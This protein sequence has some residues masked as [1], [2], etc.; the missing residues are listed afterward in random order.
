MANRVTQFVVER[1]LVN[2]TATLARTT[3]FVVERLVVFP[4][5]GNWNGDGATAVSLSALRIGYGP[6]EADGVTNVGFTATGKHLNTPLRLGKSG[7]GG[8]SRENAGP[9]T[10]KITRRLGRYPLGGGI[11][12]LAYTGKQSSV[13]VTGVTNVYFRWQVNTVTDPLTAKLAL[14]FSKL[15]KF[16]LGYNAQIRST[17]TLATAQATGATSVAIT[18][19]NNTSD[20]NWERFQLPNIDTGRQNVATDFRKAGTEPVAG[21]LYSLAN[22]G[23]KKILP[24][25]A[26]SQLFNST[27]LSFITTRP[28]LAADFKE[29]Y[30]FNTTTVWPSIS[31]FTGGIPNGNTFSYYRPIT[32][33]HSQVSGTPSNFP[34]LIQGTFSWLA[35]VAN[36]GRLQ[37][38]NGYDIS[39][40]VNTNGTGA[41]PYEVESYSPT[42]GAVTIWV[43]VPQLSS[44][45]DTTFYIFYGSVSVSSSLASPSNVWDGN[46]KGVYHLGTIG[47]ALSG[48]DSTSNT[49]TLSLVNTPTAVTGKIGGGG[50]FISASSQQLTTA[51][52][53]SAP[54]MTYEVWIKPNSFPH[55]YNTVVSTSNGGFN[56][57]FDLH[58]KSTAKVASYLTANSTVAYDGTGTTTLSAGTWYHIVQTYDSVSGLITYVNGSVD[59]TAAA[60]GA[61]QGSM[62]RFEVGNEFSQNRFFD[63]LIDEVRV[64][65]IARSASWVVTS[66][67]NQSTPGTFL[68]AGTEVAASTSVFAGSVF[69]GSTGLSFVYHIDRIAKVTSGVTNVVGF[70]CDGFASV[71]ANFSQVSIT[72]FQ[73]TGTST[74]NFVTV[75]QIQAGFAQIAGVTN[76]SLTS[77]KLSY[78]PW[79]ADGA[80]NVQF[81]SI[82]GLIGGFEADGSLNFA[83]TGT[84]VGIGNIQGD[85]NTA[86]NTFNSR[87]IWGGVIQPIGLTSVAIN[88]NQTYSFGNLFTMNGTTAV[89][90]SARQS[91]AENMQW[92]GQT[93]IT[94]PDVKNKISNAPL[95]MDGTGAFVSDSIADY[96]VQI[97]IN[98][99]TDF[100]FGTSVHP[101]IQIACSGVGDLFYQAIRR[102]VFSFQ[103]D[104]VTT[105]SPTAIR[106][107]AADSV[108]NMNGI[109]SF[110]EAAVGRYTGFI[111]GFGHTD[112]SVNTT[113]KIV[114]A[115]INADGSVNFAI[116]GA[117]D[118]FA[119]TIFD[120]I[121]QEMSSLGSFIL[122]LTT[123]QTITSTM[124]ANGIHYVL[125]PNYVFA[126]V[127][128]Q[129][130]MGNPD[131][132][133]NIT[134]SFTL[135]GKT[136]RASDVGEFGRRKR[137]FGFG[138]TAPIGSL[139]H[140][141][142]VS[143]SG[144]EWVR[145]NFFVDTELDFTSIG[146]T[147]GFN[148]AGK[149]ALAGYGT[150]GHE[151]E[152][153]V[154]FAVLTNVRNTQATLETLYT[155]NPRVDMTQVCYEMIWTPTSAVRNTQ[156]VTEMLYL[157]NLGA[158]QQV[159]VEDLY[160]NSI[161]GQQSSLLNQVGI[162]LLH[163]IKAR[164][165]LTQATLEALATGNP[166]TLVTQSAI[167]ILFFNN[168][169]R[170]S[171]SVINQTAV[172]TVQNANPNA[173]LNQLVM[174]AVHN[175][176]RNLWVN[177]VGIET[178]HNNTRNLIVQ[179]EAVE[180]VHSSLRNLLVKQVAIEMLIR[181]EYDPTVSGM[182]NNP[183]YHI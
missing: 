98:N 133:A 126:L 165:Q 101:Y 62:V 59:G 10:R 178:V 168:I 93:D 31:N 146:N 85:G 34:V 35:T 52:S 175:N 143:E 129:F 127:A 47:T 19:I 160:G 104:G 78:G 25:K 169:P 37:N 106:L 102:I 124:T 11:L 53:P 95:N 72:G 91:F 122:N 9:N 145:F 36:G 134:D 176:L 177:Q 157:A 152:K 29:Q 138:P 54:A 180:A 105:V 150:I 5:N 144:Q 117:S 20:G 148:A 39:F 32:V 48:A 171:T 24:G 149:A 181:A 42:T 67:N 167:E 8:T 111:I 7:F 182:A 156:T 81:T 118:Q 21:N 15:A 172:E 115:T 155:G 164:A 179:N 94:F 103:A 68:S 161:N 23:F 65:N 92:A 1:L 49:N 123:N 147:L 142:R 174:E 66:Y 107:L 110:A 119:T 30:F 28:P 100:Q 71:T 109:T 136:A 121:D 113:G 69:R 61:A 89:S 139:F 132:P 173:A 64:S 50:Q 114:N 158:I 4:K 17:S 140:K 58:I 76:V 57:Y 131:F 43:K 79:E 40:A 14:N 159:A 33:A 46:Y 162:E 87:V 18:A 183:H 80:T 141:M 44:S 151:I 3:Q 97:N 128:D 84:R 170:P 70:E 90:Y 60:N 75:N 112:L 88:S 135:G 137:K 73:S 38:A 166:N 74:T 116:N 163:S 96:F 99:S 16:S 2:S 12:S 82:G 22:F 153:F 27:R 6:L 51:I 130:A 154:T 83:L 55:P 125:G 56:A 108:F 86:I 41:C 26:L 13:P 120:Q 45:V 77:S 63:G